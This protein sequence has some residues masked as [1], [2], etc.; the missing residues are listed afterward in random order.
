MRIETDFLGEMAMDDAVYYGIQTERARLNF[1][2]SGRLASDVPYYIA[3]IAVLKQAAAKAN[4]AIGALDKAQADAIVQACEE[5][6]AGQFADQFPIDVFQ[7]GGGTSSNMNMNEVL[8]N[9]ANEILTG[10]KGYD[11]VHPNTHVNMG[12][13]TNDVIPAAMKVTSYQAVNG[14]I[15]EVAKLEAVLAQKTEDFADIVKLARTCLQ[16]AVPMTFGQQFSGY[17]HQVKRLHQALITANRGNLE[18]PLGATAVG[19][20]LST[21]EGYLDRVYEELQALTDTPYVAEENFFDG[22]QNGDGYLEVAA[23]VKKLAVFLSK[24]ATDF[25]IQSSGPRA[26]FNELI[27]PAVQPGSSIMPGKINPV[28]PE[29][30]NQIA[31]Q[32]I[33]NDT[34]ITMA[35]EGGELDLNVWE[36]VIIKSLFESIQLLTNTLPLFIEKC[37]ADIEPNVDVAREYAE[38]STALATV[39]ASLFGYKVGC[40]VASAAFDQNKRVRDVVLEQGILTPE[41]ADYLLDPMVMTDPAKSAAAIR[42]YQEEQ[43]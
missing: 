25:R 13:S 7:G 21:H 9:R 24:M 36:P 28:M 31:Y 22:L 29:L 12:Q 6:I 10:Q 4:H 35:V 11:A 42:R 15:D 17:Y 19:T 43:Q 18:L 38:K 16:D 39:I 8:A 5:V 37:I 2:V 34:A 30:V 23:Q 27:L 3:S 1:A 40:Q 26:G 32:I 14:L 33:G 20:G 41:Q